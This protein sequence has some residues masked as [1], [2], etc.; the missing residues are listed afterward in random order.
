MESLHPE[1]ERAVRQVLDGRHMVGAQIA[2]VADLKAQSADTE[3]AQA[4]LDGL[5]LALE[6][7]CERLE[8]LLTLVSEEEVTVAAEMLMPATAV[9]TR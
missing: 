5:T 8:R 3:L 4:R 1:F 9:V 6:G 7:N 2:I